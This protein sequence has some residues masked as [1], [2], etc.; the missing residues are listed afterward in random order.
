MSEKTTHSHTHAC[1]LPFLAGPRSTSECECFIYLFKEHPLVGLYEG[2]P[3]PHLRR[4]LDRLTTAWLVAWGQ[5]FPSHPP[6][7]VGPATIRNKRSQ[8]PFSPF[9]RR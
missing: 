2:P 6:E 9:S 1:R 3:G 4:A 8:L 5:R 7:L